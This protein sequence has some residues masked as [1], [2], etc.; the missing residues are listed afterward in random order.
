MPSGVFANEYDQQMLMSMC[1]SY[2]YYEMLNSETV[3]VGVSLT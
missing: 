2:K 1:H 3:V